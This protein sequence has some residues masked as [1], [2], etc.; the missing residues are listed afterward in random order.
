MPKVGYTVK[1]VSLKTP[2]NSPALKQ[3]RHFP[4]A[5]GGRSA[6]AG[7]ARHAKRQ[8]CPPSIPASA[9]H[10][11]TLFLHFCSIPRSFLMP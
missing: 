1:T 9:L 8:R 10:F 5:N 7:H 3:W 4:A 11:G 6:C 2:P